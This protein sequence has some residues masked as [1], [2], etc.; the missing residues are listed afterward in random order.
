MS[1]KNHPDDI[2]RK[3]D[4]HIHCCHA[5]TMA[6]D[7][8]SHRLACEI[9]QRM[10]VYLDD[11]IELSRETDTYSFRPDFINMFGYWPSRN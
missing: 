6:L 8:D 2:L 4:E 7:M 3:L 1:M 10:R 11:V 9:G 5:C